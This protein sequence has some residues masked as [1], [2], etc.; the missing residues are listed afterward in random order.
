MVAHPLGIVRTVWML[1]FVDLTLGSLLF[2]GSRCYY[3]LGLSLIFSL[4]PRLSLLRSLVCTELPFSGDVMSFA[5]EYLSAITTKCE[6]G[7]VLL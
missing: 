6:V 3:G 1:A 7:D 5:L 4:L 2:G